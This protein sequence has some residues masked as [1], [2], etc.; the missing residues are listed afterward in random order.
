MIQNHLTLVFRH[1]IDP[2]YG[3]KKHQ[4]DLNKIHSGPV[5]PSSSVLMRC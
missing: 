5:G 3:D 4:D 2:S 1:E